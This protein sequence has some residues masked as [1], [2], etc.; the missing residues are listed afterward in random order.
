[1]VEFIEKF[2]DFIKGLVKKMQDFIKD[3][4]AKND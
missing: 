4:R 2:I 3:T 1:M